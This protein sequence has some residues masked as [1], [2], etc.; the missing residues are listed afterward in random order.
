MNR[1]RC[2]MKAFTLIE[3]MI[4]LLIVTVMTSL[5]L[6]TFHSLYKTNE[7]QHFL[8]IVQQDLYLAQQTAIATGVRTFFYVDNDNGFYSIKQRTNHL[9]I[10]PF[11][12]QF[13]IV[14][15]TL[16]INE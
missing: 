3:V 15:G 16:R 4:A 1:Q 14:D 13:S 11:D 8:N 12:E 6:I 10:Q 7:I 2:S 9:F 5:T